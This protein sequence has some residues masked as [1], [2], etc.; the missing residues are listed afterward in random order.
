MRSG[1]K[2]PNCGSGTRA[3]FHNSTQPAS[4]EECNGCR[5]TIGS[6]LSTCSPIY[7]QLRFGHPLIRKVQ[8][9][10]RA[11]ASF[12]RVGSYAAIQPCQCLSST[13]LCD[14]K[15]HHHPP[16]THR[17]TPA[18]VDQRNGATEEALDQD[19]G[20]CM[21]VP[22]LNHSKIHITNPIYIGHAGNV[23][24]RGGMGSVP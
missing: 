6:V 12:R 21:P 1:G 4:K 2:E 16:H 15:R 23:P 10:R 5:A 13:P 17:T 8:P 9:N 3:Y 14:Q 19:A 20:L 7:C 11:N 24:C 22:R 18:R